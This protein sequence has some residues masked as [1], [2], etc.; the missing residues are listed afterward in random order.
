[1]KR[2]L[3]MI[4]LAVA[5]PANIIA[6]NYELNRAKRLIENEEY[7]EAALLLRPLAENGNPEAQYLAGGLFVDG[8]GVIK[9][10]KQA[11]KYYILAMNGGYEQ[12]AVALMELYERMGEEEKASELLIKLC[13]NESD[14]EKSA[15]AYK[16]GEYLYHGYGNIAI[17]KLRGWGIMYRSGNNVKHLKDDFYTSLI[18][19]HKDNPEGLLYLLC[20][21]YWSNSNTKIGWT[22]NYLDDVVSVIKTE[23]KEKQIEYLRVCDSM[24]VN[25]QNVA[26]AIISSI[27]YAEGI[28]VDNGQANKAKSVYS[29][30]V[31]DEIYLLLYNNLYK[32]AESGENGHIKRGD[33]PNFWTVVFKDYSERKERWDF[34]KKRENVKLCKTG[35][36]IKLKSCKAY[37]VD[38]ELTVAFEILNTSPNPTGRLTCAKNPKYQYKGKYK[39]NATIKYYLSK[40]YG[41][42]GHSTETF[43]VKFKEYM[44]KAGEFDFIEFTLSCDYGNVI[45]RAEDV[46]WN[47]NVKL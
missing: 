1:M 20:D 11:E 45:I 24:Y 28:G 29:E 33:F 27:M 34:L 8:K 5:V 6:Q 9:S 44:P 2:I 38:G 43:Y 36:V 41:M 32:H 13:E 30:A 16:Y 10:E 12:A 31:D 21:Y 4:M 22:A 23:E 18:N 42:K 47:D 46:V 35:N 37:M 39:Q 25:K 15:L 7:K 14:I 26:A 3:I 17:N 19:E 40:D